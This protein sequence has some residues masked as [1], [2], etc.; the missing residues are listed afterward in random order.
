[1]APL[2]RTDSSCQ[3]KNCGGVGQDKIE[4]VR[5]YASLILVALLLPANALFAQGDQAAG[6]K[7]YQQYCAPCHGG[8][9]KGD[10]PGARVLPVK[11]ADH[12]DGK[13]MN[14]R[15]DQFLFDIIAKGGSGVKR[16][17][18]MPAWGNQLSEAQI[19]DLV[20]YIRSLAASK[21]SKTK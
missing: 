10:G 19:R 18:Y 9:G 14:G 17:P 6:K 7:H 15:S 2:V 8:K 5:F 4:P 21:D 1:M 20:A 12:T 16:S 3:A 13:V 11:P